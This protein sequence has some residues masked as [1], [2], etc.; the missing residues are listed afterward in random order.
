MDHIY[1]MNK[2]RFDDQVVST[3]IQSDRLERGKKDVHGG[4]KALEDEETAKNRKIMQ[5]GQE[6][7]KHT[8]GTL[9]KAKEHYVATKEKHK[10][11][12][13][14]MGQVVDKYL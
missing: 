10:K 4:P 12:M 2:Q 3:Y 6:T 8:M 5:L 14:V 13:E 7:R 9:E 11:E 1:E